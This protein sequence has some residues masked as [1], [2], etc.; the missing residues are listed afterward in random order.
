M[1]TT[2]A[3]LVLAGCSFVAAA[4]VLAPPPDGGKPEQ[5]GVVKPEIVINGQPTPAKVDL[6]ADQQKELA[7]LKEWLR[8]YSIKPEPDRVGK[9]LQDLARL[10]EMNSGARGW[11]SAAYVAEFLRRHPDRTEEWCK[12][13][14]TGAEP[15]RYWFFTG[16]WFA[17]TTESQKAIDQRLALPDGNARRLTYTYLKQQPQSILTR[18]MR[19]DQQ[20][21]M[22]MN[23]YAVSGNNEYI[24]KLI[25]GL[26]DP[27]TDDPKVTAK[28]QERLRK[29][30]VAA[31]T[32][33]ARACRR[34][35][36]ARAF[37][38]EQVGKQP[39]PVKTRL[40][41]ALKQAGGSEPIP[42]APR[43]AGD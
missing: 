40:A 9:A 18:R 36:A 19:G 34:Y 26:N 7:E 12:L 33:L 8:N 43:V 39:D 25:E 20:I 35:E 41:E 37:C 22:L 5:P 27:P 21:E 30:A 23:A 2:A 4:Q 17:A 10:G 3:F 11:P 38:T 14:E 15:A 16:V 42:D 13:F 32:E 6:T 24:A 28:G 1:R 29:V 31:R